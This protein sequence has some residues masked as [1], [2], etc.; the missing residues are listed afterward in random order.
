MMPSQKEIEERIFSPEQQQVNDIFRFILEGNQAGLHVALD[1][2][3]FDFKNIRMKVP[4]MVFFDQHDTVNAVTETVPYNLIEAAFMAKNFEAFRLLHEDH[5]LPLR[6]NYGLRDLWKG[7]TGLPLDII[8]P[9]GFAEIGELNA[10]K[11]L[12]ERG[13]PVD[14]STAEISSLFLPLCAYSKILSAA[15][16]MEEMKEGID[17]KQKDFTQGGMT[18]QSMSVLIPVDLIFSEDVQDKKR[19]YEETLKFLLRNGA[20]VTNIAFIEAENYEYD[21][22]REVGSNTVKLSAFDIAQGLTD[23]GMPNWLFSMFE[24]KRDREEWMSPTRQIE[25]YAQTTFIP[26]II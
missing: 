19:K 4:A 26:P 17:I 25:Y 8:A 14:G 2:Y 1:M 7:N 24:E 16:D 21:I 6:R 18:V 11:Y 12:K 22:A 3:D 9:L 5:G 15:Q 20:S 13:V 10:L 23:R